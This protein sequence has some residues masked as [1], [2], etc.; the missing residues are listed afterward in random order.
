LDAA[1]FP[2]FVLGVAAGKQGGAAPA[3]FNAANE[4][5]V[6]LFLEGRVLFRD[7]GRAISGALEALGGMPGDT[8]DALLAADA[9]ARRHVQE[10]FGC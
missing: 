5:A 7:I 2:A 4:A 3:V 6:A 1:R 10:R 8:R 9:A